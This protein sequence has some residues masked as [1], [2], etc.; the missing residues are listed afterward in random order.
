VNF[1]ASSSPILVA[2]LRPENRLSIDEDFLRPYRLAPPPFGPLGAIVH[3]RTYAAEVEDPLA[4]GGVRLEAWWET[5]RRVVEGF[6]GYTRQQVRSTGQRWDDAEGQRKMQRAFDLHFR[7]CWTAP[8]R[9]LEHMGRSTVEV[10]GAGVLQNCGMCSTRFLA[11]DFAHPFATVFDYSMLG[12]GMGFDTAGA[13]TVVLVEPA[14]SDTGYVVEDTREGW[15]EALATL[16]RAFVGR[17]ELPLGWNT[18]RIRPEGAPLR[19]MGK[20]AAG[21]EALTDLLCAVEE[22]LRAHVGRPFSVTGIVDVMNLVG[23]CATSGQRRSAEIALGGARDAEFASLKDDSALRS[24]RA[25]QAEV[26]ARHA[27]AAERSRQVERLRAA[28][29]GLS[30]LSE[31]FLAMQRRIVQ[32]EA[33]REAELSLDEEWR[34][35]DAAIKRH[36]H[37]QLGPSHASSKLL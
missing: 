23:R 2:P 24:L 30:V 14:V 15:V 32:V 17:G 12:I 9:G 16:C 36:P 11:Q 29:A 1:P 13:G 28:S 34:R 37:Q 10:K 19:T 6:F 5:T 22:V 4:P 18:S 33:E 21:P 35:I 26:E 27:G 7:G 20:H 8:G 3:A 25:E 31:E